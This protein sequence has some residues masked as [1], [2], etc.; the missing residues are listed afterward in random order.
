M[1]KYI[2]HI[3][4][5]KVARRRRLPQHS[6]LWGRLA[7]F[8]EPGFWNNVGR[9]GATFLDSIYTY[10]IY[11]CSDTF[12]P[13]KMCG[14]GMTNCRIQGLCDVTCSWALHLSIL[15]CRC[16]HVPHSEFEKVFFFVILNLEFGIE[17][18]EF[19]HLTTRKSKLWCLSGRSFWFWIISS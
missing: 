14:V 1:L 11:G 12:V 8:R 16:E 4:R 17:I 7:K 6:R 15:R 5:T 9:N 13:E 2:I 3:A 19:G 18:L 10:A